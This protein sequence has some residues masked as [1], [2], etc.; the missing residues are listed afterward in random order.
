MSEKNPK[1]S[2]RNGNENKNRSNMD[3][4]RY[5]TQFK[6][7]SP[8]KNAQRAGNSSGKTTLV[9]SQ[10]PSIKE[11]QLESICNS[12][13]ETYNPYGK[14]VYPQNYNSKD[15]INASSC[16]H[17][18]GNS[19]KELI[20]SQFK[21]LGKDSSS[22]KQIY[23]A[24]KQIFDMFDE[25]KMERIPSQ[26][27]KGLEQVMSEFLTIRKANNSGD[28]LANFDSFN[29]KNSE[30]IKE[31][32]IVSDLELEGEILSKR[33]FELWIL[34][35]MC[36]NSDQL[37]IKIE[38]EVRSEMKRQYS[39]RKLSIDRRNS[40]QSQLYEQNY[41]TPDNLES[42]Q[43]SRRSNG[44]L[45]YSFNYTNDC[46]RNSDR[47]ENTFHFEIQEDMPQNCGQQQKIYLDM[48]KYRTNQ[49][50]KGNAI[51][52]NGNFLKNYKQPS[53]SRESFEA[54]DFESRV[55]STK[56][57]VEVMDVD[58]I[59]LGSDY[60]EE[61]SYESGRS[62]ASEFLE[63]ESLIME[64]AKGEELTILTGH[65]MTEVDNRIN[66]L[67]ELNKKKEIDIKHAR[68]CVSPE[69]IEN[70]EKVYSSRD[71]ND[72]RETAES[73]N[74]LIGKSVGKISSLPANAHLKVGMAKI[75]MSGA[76]DNR[77]HSGG[78]N[79]SASKKYSN[80]KTTE[81]EFLNELYDDQVQESENTKK[82]SRI[83]NTERGESS[84][85]KPKSMKTL[86]VSFSF[87]S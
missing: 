31:I 50:R 61:E 54:V 85:A 72:R 36:D 76:A 41:L 18:S 24:A 35:Y 82:D 3:S 71:R 8:P 45:E 74:R 81:I 43:P 2:Q 47:T 87:N 78:K 65:G 62:I 28:N 13:R 64:Q 6:N 21:S 32:N 66:T 48:K 7:Y 46:T 37:N 77:D 80:K 38:D 67:A 10:K 56:K 79:S 68:T 84:E 33:D 75:V 39:N 11:S 25:E 26:K 27:I 19:L 20:G 49:S 4:E 34:K 16:S 58:Q 69:K 44:E 1:D 63:E 40:I 86:N 53:N 17:I 22:P 23:E 9:L 59:S 70:F 5:F 12:R 60:E 30:K 73:F 42:L 51:N 29:P 55:E 15:P 52:P 14:R 83:F 57:D